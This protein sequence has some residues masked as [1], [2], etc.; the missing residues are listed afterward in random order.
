LGDPRNVKRP[1]TEPTSTRKSRAAPAVG[2]RSAAGAPVAPRTPD[3]IAF[4]ELERRLQDIDIP[5]REL[6]RYLTGDPSVS[7]P[8]APVIRADPKRVEFDDMDRFRVEGAFAMNWANG[9]ARWRRQTRFKRR[10]L[11]GERLPVVVAEGDSWFQFPF[12]LDDIVDQFDSTYHIW[13]ISAAGDTLMRM[14]N[15]APEYIEAIAEQEELPKLLMFS[16]AG[17]DIVG[18]EPDGTSVVY[19]VLRD[20]EPGRPAGWYLETD[21][22]AERLTFV[23]DAYRKLLDGVEREFGGRVSVVLHGYDYAIPAGPGDP[24][25]PS[26]ARVDEWLGAPLTDRGI[27]EPVLRRQIIRLMI[28]RLNAVQQRLCGGDGR[29]GEYPTAFHVDVRNTLAGISEWADELHPTDT[30]FRKVADRFAP[31]LAGILRQ[32]ERAMPSP[33]RKRASLGHRGTESLPAEPGSVE[34]R[35]VVVR[36]VAEALSSRTRR[37]ALE[38]AARLPGEAADE[39]ER[40]EGIDGQP[41]RNPGV[42]IP[43]IDDPSEEPFSDLGPRAPV[44]DPENMLA[45]FRKLRLEAAI[46]RELTAPAALLDVLSRRRRAVAR[47][48]AHGTD[49]RGEHHTRDWHGTGFLVGR[50]LLLTNHHVLNSV[51]VARDAI[52]EFDYEVPAADLLA[53]TSATLATKTFGLDPARLFV[54]SPVDGGLD[55]TFVWIDEAAERE[56]GSIAMERASFTVRR[57]EQ[58]YIIHHPRGDPKQ[59]SLDDTDVLNI[60]T[61]VIHYSSD[62]DYGSS[63]APVLDR[64]GRLVA[65]HHARDERPFPLPDGGTTNVVNEGIKIGAIA[66]ELENRV[67]AEAPDAA[68]AATALAAIKGSDSL[69]GFFG[70]LGRRVRPVGDVEAVVDTYRGTGQDIDVGFWNIEWLSNRYRETDRLQAAARVIADLNLDVWG[71]SEVSPPAVE[72]LVREL[73][74]LFGERYAYAF[75]EPSASE[76]RQTTAVIWKLATVRGE[77][78]SWPG[79]VEHL[80]HLDS[81]DPRAREE[82]VHGKIFDRYPGLFRFSLG[83]DA[84]QRGKARTPFDFHLVPL[85]L[86]AMAEG[87]LRRRLASRILTRAVK[88]L[89]EETGDADVVLGGDVNAPLA[90]GDFDALRESDFTPMSAEDE[91]AGGFTY[92]KS[93]RSLI[94][95]IFLSPN[96]T[97]TAGALDYFIVAKERTVDEF[98]KKVSDHRPVLLRISLLDAGTAATVADEDVDLDQLIDRLAA[99][100]GRARP[101]RP[102]RSREQAPRAG[103]PTGKRR[104]SSGSRT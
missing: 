95:S 27:T 77:R 73:Q 9:I 80:F 19:R 31:V 63:G 7:G 100:Q 37:E 2:R 25:R 96:L 78:V 86:K 81:R 90:S 76:G 98:V 70:G 11:F 16:G 43:F 59:V 24:R 71:L 26:W 18:E 46:G 49:F 58:A 6:R 75:S 85:H 40:H 97:K 94:D 82:A 1:V 45:G 44:D 21:A 30:G 32:E 22:F 60:Q 47:I 10:R 88:E 84:A 3:K 74:E 41:V 5:D 57:G 101:A 53:G 29:S 89:I 15:D 65:L 52:V 54:T 20:F 69:T 66:V 61:T 14:V 99:E 68:M 33:R 51:E 79:E 4:S 91:A 102:S 39:D 36:A 87:S 56:Q 28:D 35:D 72:A 62:T 55:F 92:L 8:F 42:D 67:K 38:D 13:C 83:G 103:K 104:A 64:Q 23:E 50:N 34:L 17:N 12:L 48:G 93:P